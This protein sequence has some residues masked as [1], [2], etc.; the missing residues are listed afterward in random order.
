VFADLAIWVDPTFRN[1]ELFNLASPLN[2]NRSLTMWAL[3]HR[4]LGDEGKKCHT[5]DVFERRGEIPEIALL[6]DL[7]PDVTEEPVPWDR[8]VRRWLILSESAVVLPTNWLPTRHEAFEK[9]F[10]WSDPLVDNERYFKLN[11]PA[12]FARKPLFSDT[13]KTGFCTVIAGEK[14]SSHPLEL[15]SERR[16]AIKWFERNHPDELDLYGHGWDLPGLHRS[17]LLEG[18]NHRLNRFAS[19]RRLAGL[20]YASYRGSI[21]DKYEVLSRYRFSICYE[22]AYGIDGYITEKIFDCFLAGTVPIYLGAGNITAH[23]PAE[24]FIDKRG[25]A[26]YEELYDYLEGLST[27]TYGEYLRAAAAFIASEQ[28]LP[29]TPEHVATTLLNAM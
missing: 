2:A 12:L 25:F 15:Y 20:R 8:S 10:T 7:P 28:A 1:D 5:S 14:G 4:R 23:V 3:L 24:C 21:G 19:Y 26:S 6:L 18:I 22:N 29:F 16:N 17:Q 9:I 11:T 27:E 13:P